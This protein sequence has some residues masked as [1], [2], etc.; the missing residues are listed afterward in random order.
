M[1]RQLKRE[2]ISRRGQEGF[3][4]TSDGIPSG[5]REFQ[6]SGNYKPAFQA[7]AQHLA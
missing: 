6:S 5:Y 2:K 1:G 3:V 7:I 4:L